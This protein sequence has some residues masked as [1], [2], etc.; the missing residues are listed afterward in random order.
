MRGGEVG[1]ADIGQCPPAAGEDRRAIQKEPV[2]QI[3]G[4]ERSGG[5]RTTLDEQVVD[6]GEMRDLGRR[7]DPFPPGNVP[8]RQ[9]QAPRRPPLQP[10]QP[11]VERGRVRLQ[12]P[13]PDQRL[14]Q[15]LS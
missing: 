1:K 4:E 8:P 7:L 14:D 11:H 9:H 10:G 13:A 5:G 15:N 3:G 6:E 12:R 2:N